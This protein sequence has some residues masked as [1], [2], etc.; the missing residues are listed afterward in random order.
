MSR[1]A[2]KFRLKHA[3]SEEVE[4][5]PKPKPRRKPAKTIGEDG[6]LCLIPPSTE[7][8]LPSNDLLN[9]FK[10]SFKYLFES[11]DMEQF[12]Q[13]VKGDLYNRDYQK[14]FSDDDRRMAYCVRWTPSRALAYS[15]LFSSLDEV[16]EVLTQ[17]DS[18]VLS[19]G[20][21][22]GGELVALSSLFAASKD[23]LDQEAEKFQ[24]QVDLVD[25]ADWSNIVKK[26]TD[27]VQSNWLYSDPES[28]KVNFIQD[29]VLQLDEAY[30]KNIPTLDLITL[31]FTT[32]ELFAADR[33]KSIRFFQSLSKCKKGAYLLISESAGSFSHITVG[34]K[35]FPIQFLID[36]VLL[37]KDTKSGD[38]ELVNQSESCW[39][40][41]APDLEYPLK[42]ENMRFFFRLYRRK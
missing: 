39:Y 12:I 4:E 40:R 28:M 26:L 6:F 35:K 32:N 10:N 11:E 18:H 16:R 15:S 22:A 34:T 9:L 37:G 21:G 3:E 2:E 14:A 31:L 36:T 17:S 13:V 23:F 38:W 20:G 29:D 24:L 19:V 25:I 5:V 42:L 41:C 27:Q 33:A 8:T 1:R 30:S 7:F